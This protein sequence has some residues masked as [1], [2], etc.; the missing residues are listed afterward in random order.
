MT[1]TVRDDNDGVAAN[2]PRLTGVLVTFNRPADLARYLTALEQQ[3]RPLDSLVIVDNSPSAAVSNV[4]HEKPLRRT[5]VLYL[6]QDR[7]LGPAGGYK[8]A[9]LKALE[10][11]RESGWIVCLDDDDPP[12]RDDLFEQLLAFAE[13]QC[14]RDPRTACVGPHGANYSRW[15]GL[16]KRAY[17]RPYRGAMPILVDYI[18]NGNFP[19]YAAAAI[20]D[21]GSF[22]DRL[23]F[24]FEDADLG[25]RLQRAG[26]RT[27]INA[28]LRHMGRKQ[29][30]SSIAPEPRKSHVGHELAWRRYYSIR[31]IVW[32]ARQHAYPGVWLGLAT[33]Y[34]LKALTGLVTRKD[35]AVTAFRLTWMALRD[36]S[37]DELGIREAPGTLFVAAE[38]RAPRRVS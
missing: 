19:M 6:P 38:G 28:G 3:T 17:P 8:V 12:W 27:Y 31:N 24:G 26:Y 18:G 9:M 13:A 10:H 14:V 11:A 29:Q 15:T 36:A 4:I 34:L 7:N 35:T 5:S 22:E 2:E 25:L 23:F 37:R 32:I 20:K 1:S 33:A 30:A 21:A 16:L